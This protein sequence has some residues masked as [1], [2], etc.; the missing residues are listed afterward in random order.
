M[1]P[2]VGS[3]RR[4]TYVLKAPPRTPTAARTTMQ[5]RLTRVST[6]LLIAA[7]ACYSDR[8][9]TL[10]PNHAISDGAHSGGTPGFFFLPPMVSQPAVTGR[11]DP[12]IVALNPVVLICDVKIG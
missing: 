11:F 3:L 7:A 10:D 5:L 4:S 6:L 12:D 9:G 8:R 1:S 2:H